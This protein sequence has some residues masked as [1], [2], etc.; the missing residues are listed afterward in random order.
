[1]S[2]GIILVDSAGNV[3]AFVANELGKAMFLH[4]KHL[5]VRR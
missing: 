5:S 3:I 4:A 1:M 2:T